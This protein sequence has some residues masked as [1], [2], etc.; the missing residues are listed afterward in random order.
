MTTPTTREQLRRARRNSILRPAFR[1][2]AYGVSIAAVA[3]AIAL[4]W[5]PVES[6][7]VILPL[8]MAVFYVD[9]NGNPQQ[10]TTGDES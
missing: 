9:K 8:L 1:R 6:A 3:A 2:W 4:G 7:P 10:P 5:L